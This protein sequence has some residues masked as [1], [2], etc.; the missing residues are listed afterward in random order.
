[1]ASAKRTRKP[2]HMAIQDGNISSGAQSLAL[3]ITHHANK[4]DEETFGIFTRMG[5]HYNDYEPLREELLRA[6]YEASRR[7]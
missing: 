4:N 6:G 7:Y 1:M 2:L 3:L 5:G